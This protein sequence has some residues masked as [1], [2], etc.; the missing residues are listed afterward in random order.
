[1]ETFTII[2]NQVINANISNGAFRLFC[3]LSKY[4]FNSNTCF[5]SQRRLAK[6]VC[7]GVCVRTIQRWLTILKKA[8]LVDVQ[9]RSGTSS[10]YTILKK[11]KMQQQRQNKFT[12]YVK[13]KFKNNGGRSKNERHYDAEALEKF[14]LNRTEM[15]MKEIQK[16]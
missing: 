6:E 4:C 11:I 12:E 13:N 5:P 16:E 14:L 1:M 15:A 10:I 8:H 3:L 2:N 9:F 7:G